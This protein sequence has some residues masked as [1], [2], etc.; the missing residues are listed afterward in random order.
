MGIGAIAL[1]TGSV[2]AEDIM[3]SKYAVA[4]KGGT[5]GAG[6]EITTPILENINLRV[7][8]NGYNYSTSGSKSNIDYDIDLKLLTVDLLADYYPIKSSQFRLTG[9]I[10]YNGNKLDMTGNAASAGTFTFN[11]VSYTTAQVGSV[12][13][14]VDFNKIAPYLGIG[15]GNAVKSAGWNFIADLG[16]MFQGT[17]KSDIS[18]NTTL[19][20]ATR[21][22]LLNNVAAEQSKLDDDLSGYEY[23][24]VATVGVSYR[25]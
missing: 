16:V 20:G 21:T 12:D 18:V 11:G 13:A 8:I 25:F 5:T 24:P 9:G 4:L 3:F 15:W 10:M 6:V 22:A 7:G 19:T 14:T 1:F 2:F 23:Y 17:P